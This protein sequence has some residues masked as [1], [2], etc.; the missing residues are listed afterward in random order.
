L[1]TAVDTNILLDILTADTE[2]LASSRSL[3][4]RSVTEGEV[5]ISEVVY[6]EVAAF[7]D[8][9]D[10]LSAFLADARISLRPS[11]PQ[12]LFIAGLAWRRY[13]ERRGTGVHC[14]KCGRQVRVR[15]TVCHSPVTWRQHILADFLVGG[16]A[17][18]L[19]DRLLT[20]DRGYFRAYFPDLT[21][22][23]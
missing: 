8:R 16:H 3:L 23:G 21:L 20:R 22:L 18:A 6:T 5:I 4:E 11:T 17:T 19:A 2:Y 7:F 15:C 10:T 13:A 12:A 9:Q 1:I 14:P